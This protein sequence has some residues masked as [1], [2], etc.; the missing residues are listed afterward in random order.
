MEFIIA[1]LVI[2]WIFK[3][4]FIPPNFSE[5]NE[6][7]KKKSSLTLLQVI[8]AISF[9]GSCMILAYPNK[10]EI[11]ACFFLCIP[12]S[13]IVGFYF[14]YQFLHPT[15]TL[16]SPDDLTD[17]NLQKILNNK[18]NT[19]YLNYQYRTQGENPFYLLRNRLQQVKFEICLGSGVTHLIG[20]FMDCTNLKSVHSFN[21]INIT[22]VTSMFENCRS[23][24]DA[25]MLNLHNV[26]NADS[27][28][29]GC[30]QLKTVPLYDLSNLISCSYMVYSCDRICKFPKFNTKGLSKRDLEELK[31]SITL[32]FADNLDQETL[33]A[34]ELVKITTISSPQDLTDQLLTQ[35]ANNDLEVLKIAYPC[36]R[37]KYAQESLIEYYAW[38]EKNNPFF[39]IRKNLTE[40]KFA[41]YIDQRVT[42]LSYLFSGCT[43]LR[44]VSKIMNTSHVVNFS[45]MFGAMHDPEY[46]FGYTGCNSLTFVPLFDTSRGK[47]FEGMFSYCTRLGSIPEFNLTSAVNLHFMFAHCNHLTSKPNV[48]MNANATQS[49]MYIN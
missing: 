30:K 27:M 26:K 19:L 37:A 46:L 12:T 20:L 22:D 29:A 24:V 34:W 44:S 3:F 6:E 10:S 9:I 25:P 14:F 1:I 36:T 16:D 42:N 48:K 41:I 17:E 38:M 8:F 32:Y 21:T 28:F 39:R 18:I 5:E 2:Y 23:L 13:F 33:F 11:P 47:N 31:G 7:P 35:I 43:N 49:T 40:I 45:Y 15:L 4:L